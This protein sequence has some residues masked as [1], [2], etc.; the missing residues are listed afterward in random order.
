MACAMSAAVP[1]TSGRRASRAR[2]RTQRMISVYRVRGPGDPGDTPRPLRGGSGDRKLAHFGELA[3]FQ[4]ADD[5]PRRVD[6][7]AAQRE[8]RGGG[9]LVMVVVQPFAGREKR[10]GLEV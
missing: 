8:P 7:A 9:V 6:F 10:D 4:Q 2:A 1:A 5:G 3:G